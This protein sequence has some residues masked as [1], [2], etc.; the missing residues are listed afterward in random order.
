MGGGQYGKA[1][2]GIPE[3]NLCQL[4]ESETVVYPTVRKATNLP[5]TCPFKMVTMPLVKALQVSFNSIIK[6][7]VRSSEL[8]RNQLFKMKNTLCGIAS[9][10]LLNKNAQNQTETH[11]TETTM[12]GQ[13]V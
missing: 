2:L 3:T 7:R 1:P 13:I 9:K 11:L 5:A 12:R 10:L 4:V 8:L 6:W